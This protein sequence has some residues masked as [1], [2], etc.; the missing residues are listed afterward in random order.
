VLNVALTGNIAAGKSTVV[1]F[2]ERWGATIIDADALAR[3]AQ[4]PGGDRV[5]ARSRIASAPTSWL[6]TG[7]STAR[8]CG[9]R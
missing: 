7:P 1:D 8:R 3:E 6:L 4:A 2:F 9:A 5:L